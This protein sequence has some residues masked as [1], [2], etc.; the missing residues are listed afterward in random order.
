M[1]ED[2]V[3]QARRGCKEEAELEALMDTMD[4]TGVQ[5]RKALLASQGATGVQDRKA[6]LGQASERLVGLVTTLTLRAF[7]HSF[8]LRKYTSQDQVSNTV[9]AERPDY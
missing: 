9:V 3:A 8:K 6:L 1:K 4:P 7:I 5:E 2:P